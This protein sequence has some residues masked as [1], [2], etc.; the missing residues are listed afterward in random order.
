VTPTVEPRGAYSTVTVVGDLAFGAG[1]T[2]RE[3]GVLTQVGM[4]GRDASID[5]GNRAAALAATNAVLAI[6]QHVEP[7]RQLLRLAHLRVFIRAAED[8][9]ELSQIADHA[10]RA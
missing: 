5:D 3:Q 7:A 1:V 8:V 6:R 2:P 4:V 9:T 10:S